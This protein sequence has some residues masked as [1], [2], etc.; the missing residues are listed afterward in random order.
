MTSP[1]GVLFPVSLN[2]KSG[3]FEKSGIKE[4][5]C[6]GRP[7]KVFAPIPYGFGHSVGR[8][9]N[10]LEGECRRRE[11]P[12]PRVLRGP[13]ELDTPLRFTEDWQRNRTY[14]QQWAYFFT[15]DGRFQLAEGDLGH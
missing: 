11:G 5:R 4:N 2:T 9:N 7:N 8:V 3:F 15:G 10:V 12:H 14:A 13:Q 6:G 1:Q